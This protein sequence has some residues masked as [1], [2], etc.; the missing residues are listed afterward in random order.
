M[1]LSIRPED[2]RLDWESRHDERSRRF[3]VTAALPDRIPDRRFWR[4]GCVLDQGVEGSCV[5]HGWV[6]ELLAAPKGRRLADP[7]RASAYALDWYRA[8][9]QI[10]EWEGDTYSGTSV[11][12]GA[13]VG[14]DRKHYDGY[15]WAFSIDEVRDAVLGLG[16]VVIG[17]PWYKAMYRTRPSGLVEVAGEKVGGHCILVTGYHPAIQIRG[18]DRL[19]RFDVFEWFN[20]WGPT[21]GKRGRGL[22]E[23]ATLASLLA[24]DGEACVPVGR[25][26]IRVPL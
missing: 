23:R 5:G 26:P 2:R 4:R 18:E 22:I 21:Y 24:E 6:N 11:L 7:V 1:V 9:Q 12:A 17:V 8:A 3:P 20:S 10:D 19:K 16:P 15:R 13:K 14:V 25:H